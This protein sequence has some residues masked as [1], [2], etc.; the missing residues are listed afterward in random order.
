MRPL[1]EHTQVS[2][3]SRLMFALG[4]VLALVIPALRGVYP[5]AHVVPF[6]VAL[7]IFVTGALF[8]RL[9]V[10]IDRDALRVAFGLGWPR[11]LLQLKDIESV[12]LTR[13]TWVE[14]WGIRYTRRGWLWNVAGLDAV[15]LRLRSGK[16]MLI[17]TD[18]PRRLHSVLAQTLAQR[19]RGA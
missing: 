9:T 13:T 11:K 4:A 19:Q 18:E 15:L 6:V 10:R 12:E 7:A 2:W 16:S 8:S 5:G 17:G 3:L 14:G 1:Y